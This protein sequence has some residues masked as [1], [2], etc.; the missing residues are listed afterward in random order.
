MVDIEMEMTMPGADLG[1][2]SKLVVKDVGLSGAI[3]KTVNSSL[4]GL[5]TKVTSIQQAI[6]LLG[7]DN[8]FCIINS[9]SIRGAMSNDNI[10]AMTHFWDNSM[11]I[12]AACAYIARGRFL[13]PQRRCIRWVS[14]AI[15]ESR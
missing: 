1:E 13:D 3:I 12:A 6:S 10:V 7:V 9:I 15:V 4:F 11:D 2:I 5:K 8:L 14:F